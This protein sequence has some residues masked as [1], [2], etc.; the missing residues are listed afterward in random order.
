[1]ATTGQAG[2][3]AHTE[4]AGGKAAPQG[5]M[6][7]AAAATPHL[8]SQATF[9]YLLPGRY[10]STFSCPVLWVIMMMPEPGKVLQ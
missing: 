10:S 6:A 3:R 1:M 2:V 5:D 4:E 7:C 8:S 9:L